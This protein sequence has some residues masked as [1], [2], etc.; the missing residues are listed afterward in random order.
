MIFHGHNDRKTHTPSQNFPRPEINPTNQK[1]YMF[2]PDC[3][4]RGIIK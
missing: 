2:Q 1:M 4:N 3:F